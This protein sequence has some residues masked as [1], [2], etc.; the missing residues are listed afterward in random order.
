[1]EEQFGFSERLKVAME[2]RGKKA[3]DVAD[4]CGLQRGT[5]SLY[6]HNKRIPKKENIYKI[7]DYLQVNRAFLLGISDNLIV[8]DIEK[9]RVSETEEEIIIAAYKKWGNEMANHIYGMFSFALL[10]TWVFNICLSSS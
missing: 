5:I 9:G 4:G 1:M 6:L 3:I 10:V 7:A 2:F 8:W